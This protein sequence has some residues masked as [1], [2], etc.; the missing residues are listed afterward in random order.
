MEFTDHKIHLIG[1]VRF[2]LVDSINR[3]SLKEAIDMMNDKPRG[4]WC[5]VC[6]LD[7]VTDLSD[8]KKKA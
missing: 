2:N 8:L 6:A 7:E 5:L 3:P 4:A 1:T